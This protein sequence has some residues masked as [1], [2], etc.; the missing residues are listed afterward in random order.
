MFSICQIWR[1][2]HKQV[3]GIVT[4]VDQEQ[5]WTWNVSESQ[6]QAATKLLAAFKDR[7]N[8][9][10]F[11][12]GELGQGRDLLKAQIE[13]TFDPAHS[14]ARF[15]AAFQVND[16]PN[17]IQLKTIAAMKQ[18]EVIQALQRG[19][20]F[21]NQNCHALI[22]F[23]YHL[24]DEYYRPR[25]AAAL[26][27]EQCGQLKSDLFGDI[28]L[29]R[30]AIIHNQAILTEKEYS[31]LRMLTPLDELR[32]GKLKLT[33]KT[34]QLIVSGVDPLQLRATPPCHRGN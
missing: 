10:F 4:M 18:A 19:G 8:R 27:L 21:E 14:E 5:K 12:F 3:R 23:M 17:N 26:G 1:P 31:K 28:R 15:A 7:V 32:I 24:W 30:N 20:E 25:I 2:N 33:Q 22:V 11:A 6:K 29:I 13:Q 16:D 9:L 34:T